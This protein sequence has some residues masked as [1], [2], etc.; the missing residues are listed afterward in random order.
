MAEQAHQKFDQLDLD[1]SKRLGSRDLELK[2]QDVLIAQSPSFKGEIPAVGTEQRTTALDEVTKEL[3]ALTPEQR[4]LKYL[5]LLDTNPELKLITQVAH[6]QR[7]AGLKYMKDNGM[8]TGLGINPTSSLEKYKEVGKGDLAILKTQNGAGRYTCMM[9]STDVDQE[10]LLDVHTPDYPLKRQLVNVEH[11]LVMSNFLLKLMDEY[12]NGKS[13]TQ[14][15][16][17]EIQYF[18]LHEATQHKYPFTRTEW[19]AFTTLLDNAHFIAYLDPQQDK[20]PNRFRNR[21]RTETNEIV[22]TR[23]AIERFQTDVVTNPWNKSKE[24]MRSD[25][26]VA[27]AFLGKIYREIL[28]QSPLIKNSDY[29]R[30]NH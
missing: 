10:W 5:D 29:Y 21:G 24:S 28:H 12:G 26:G 13:I 14:K 27:R 25:A 9:D 15:E 8:D 1:A 11:S 2:L 6:T 17:Q 16:M 20:M 7:V 19:K 4:S 3:V 30:L 23:K 18:A 22:I